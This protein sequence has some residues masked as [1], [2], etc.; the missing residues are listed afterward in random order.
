[1]QI[2]LNDFN[3]LTDKC[4]SKEGSIDNFQW[5]RGPEDRNIEVFTDLALGMVK[6]KRDNRCTKIA[7]LLE[8]VEISQHTYGYI[9]QNEKDFDYIA[10]HDIEFVQSYNNDKVTYVPFGGTWLKPEERFIFE[11]TKNISLIASEKSQTTGQKLRHYIAA[12]YSNKID[13]YGRKYKNIELKS[14]G[15]KDY[16][17]S[18]IVENCA[19]PGYFS[20]KLIDAFLT[21]TIPVYYGD[22]NVNNIFNPRG[23]IGINT[24]TDLGVIDNLGVNDYEERLDAIKENFTI[25]LKYTAS[26]NELWSRLLYRFDD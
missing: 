13:L 23:I 18:I 22:T 3:F 16:R 20:E 2:K 21:G 17:F 5:Y 1:M 4:S 11:K 15:L 12:K 14:E 10:S 9:Q 19:R 7:W 8:P 24:D 25:A 6:I 26:E